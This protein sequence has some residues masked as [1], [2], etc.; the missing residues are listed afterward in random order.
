MS[1]SYYIALSGLNAAQTA[2]DTVSQNISNASTPGYLREQVNLSALVDQSSGAGNG[3]MVNSIGQVSSGFQNQV[4]QSAS[5][6][7]SYATSLSQVLVSGQNFLNEPSSSGISE[8]LANFWSAFDTVANSPNQLAPRQQL[9]SDAQSL[10]NTFNQLSESMTTLYNSTVNSVAT[11]VT[12][13]N[14]QIAQVAELNAQIQQAGSTSSNAL[15]DQQ[16]QLVNKLSSSF[17]VTVQTQSDGTVNLLLGGV[18]LVQ[19]NVATSLK[20]KAPT[21]PPMPG[22][23]QV[24]IVASSSGSSVPV[25]RGSVGGLLQSLNQNLPSYSASFDSVASSLAST[26]NFQLAKGYSY[27][28][29]GTTPAAGTPLFTFGGNGASTALNLGVSSAMVS[30]PFTMAAAGNPP[31]GNNDGTNAQ[32]TAELSNLVTGPDAL[33]RSTVGQFGLDASNAAALVS[34]TSTSYQS[35]YQAQQAVSGV[36]T[37]TELVN[38]LNYQ[39]G[40]QAAAKVISTISTTVQSLLQAV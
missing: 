30:D 27:P 1:G 33:W 6:Q 16:N 11:T 29:D 40:Y 13:A 12:A 26:V 39:Q 25:T 38:M 7:N 34:S 32:A 24:S 35:A 20:I 9:V 2:L 36:S 18:M 19:G 3:V 8:Q 14:S 28:G 22:P 37:N 5:A 21:A 4:L 17:G 23:D 10:S 31:G 15:K